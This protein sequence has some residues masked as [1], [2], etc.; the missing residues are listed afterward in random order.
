M[1]V[2]MAMRFYLLYLVQPIWLLAVISDYLCH[3]ASNIAGICST[4][5][6]DGVPA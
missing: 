5:C 4:R 1:T 2:E 6:E 3:R